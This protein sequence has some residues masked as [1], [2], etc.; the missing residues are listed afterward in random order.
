MVSQEVLNKHSTW[1]HNSGH[2]ILLSIL[3]SQKKYQYKD[4]Q[5]ELSSQEEQMTIQKPLEP[6]FK[7][8]KSPLN[9][10][11]TFTRKQA[12]LLT[13]MV[14]VILKKF[15]TVLDKPQC[16]T[17]YFFME[18]HVWANLQSHNNQLNKPA[19]NIYPSPNFTNRIT[20]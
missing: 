8:L 2:L 3:M 15:M 18:R 4:S 19:I 11:L 10:L 12:K 16:L 20:A 9:R 5:K 7:S 17:F 6:E 13:L 14:Q 1:S